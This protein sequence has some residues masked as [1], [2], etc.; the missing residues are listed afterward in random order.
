MIQKIFT[1]AFYVFVVFAVLLTVYLIGTSQSSSK[2]EAS[3]IM[4]NDYQATTTFAASVPLIRVLKSTAGTL[5][6]VNITGANT[7]LM[8]LY[9]ATTSDVT[10]RT[11]NKATSTIMIA[12]FPASAVA[13]NYTF[14]AEF[15]D[16]LLLVGSGSI[17]TSTITYR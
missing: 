2:V 16:G 7:G 11:G 12:D 17:A 5:N 4:G 14:D 6:A 3:T 9:N 8:T 15:S 1:N 13:N 10:K